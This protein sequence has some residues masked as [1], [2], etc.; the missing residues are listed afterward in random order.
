MNQELANNQEILTKEPSITPSETGLNQKFFKEVIES[1]QLSEE[2]E[3]QK[4]PDI[5][6]TEQEFLDDY[7][8]REKKTQSKL[9]DEKLIQ[10]QTNLDEENE[11]NKKLGQSISQILNNVI[12]QRY[13]L[14]SSGE[15]V[16]LQT[17]ALALS[18]SFQPEK[19]ELAYQVLDW[20]DEAKETGDYQTLFEK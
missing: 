15:I 13:A 9:K 1:S 2:K 16:D 10:V 4:R 19:K 6:I 14:P 17:L 8:K 20:M 3:L 12:V 11:R 18:L 5:A 7:A